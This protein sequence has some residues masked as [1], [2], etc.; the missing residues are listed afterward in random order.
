V[1][2]IVPN[3]IVDIIRTVGTGM[4][5]PVNKAV[6]GHRNN[7]IGI[8]GEIFDSGGITEGVGIFETI[9]I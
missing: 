1:S 4:S 3:A 2:V 5:I 7:G 6:F 8:S 9:K